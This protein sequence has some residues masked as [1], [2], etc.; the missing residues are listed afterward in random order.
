MAG[1]ILLPFQKMKP[2]IIINLVLTP[3][4]VLSLPWLAEKIRLLLTQ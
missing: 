3:L 4:A 2:A 1:F